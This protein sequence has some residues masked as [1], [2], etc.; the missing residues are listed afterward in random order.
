MIV[1]LTVVAIANPIFVLLMHIWYVNKQSQLLAVERADHREQISTLI[2]AGLSRTV[3][4]FTQAEVAEKKLDSVPTPPDLIGT[5]T[6]TDEQFDKLI[7]ASN[8]N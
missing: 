7:K 3:E 6:L 1:F 5:E 2:K 8:G 4:E